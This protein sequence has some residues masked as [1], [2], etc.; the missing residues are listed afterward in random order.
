M[1]N[2]LK[3]TQFLNDLKVL[4]FRILDIYTKYYKTFKNKIVYLIAFF[5]YKCFDK[6]K[7]ELI[8][9]QKKVLI[10]FVS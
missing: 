2:N 10:L 1:H 9:Y 4:K 5:M 3:F 8:F 7:V 6:Y